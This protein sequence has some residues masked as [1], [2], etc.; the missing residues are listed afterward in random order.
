MRERQEKYEQNLHR[1]VCELKG[2]LK[3]AVL[4]NRSLGN[5]Y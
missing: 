5:V 2:V 1:L 3:T 4:N